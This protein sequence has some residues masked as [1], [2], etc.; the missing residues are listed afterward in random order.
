MTRISESV[1]AMQGAEQQ[2][3][4]AL[5]AGPMTTTELIEKLGHSVGNFAL[6]KMIGDNAGEWDG[7]P[8]QLALSDMVD[9]GKVFWWKDEAFAVRYGLAGAAGVPSAE[10]CGDQ[11]PSVIAAELFLTQVCERLAA[12]QCEIEAPFPLYREIGK[13]DA[14]LSLHIEAGKLEAI[15]YDF[16]VGAGSGE[17]HGSLAWP[18]TDVSA[19]VAMVL[20]A[21]AG[22]PKD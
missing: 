14:C 13:D 9:G 7:C 15:D 8:H 17:V 6:T 10:E 11:S 18:T 12:S 2:V 19:A 21:L 1:E 3:L 4:D 20:T 16:V 22:M 5:S